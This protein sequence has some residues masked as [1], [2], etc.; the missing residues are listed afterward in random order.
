MFISS[1]VH[2]T[3]LKYTAHYGYTSHVCEADGLVK[4]PG[5]CL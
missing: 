3:K 4:K 2:S 5:V 1:F